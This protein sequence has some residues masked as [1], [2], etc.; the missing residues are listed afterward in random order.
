LKEY[1]KRIIRIIYMNETIKENRQKISLLQ[2]KLYYIENK[3]QVN[4]NRKNYK[5]QAWADRKDN[6]KNKRNII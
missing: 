3:P 4:K 5:R 2:R 1:L 6:P